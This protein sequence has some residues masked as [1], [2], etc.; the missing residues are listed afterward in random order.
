MYRHGDGEPMV[1]IARQ[2]RGRYEYLYECRSYRDGE[3]RPRSDRVMIGRVDTVTG[4]FIPKRYHNC[5]WLDVETGEASVKPL[6]RVP[7][8]YEPLS[9][10]SVFNPS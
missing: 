2:I 1:F 3:G 7:S 9:E 5:G 4:E 10:F 6:P 8:C